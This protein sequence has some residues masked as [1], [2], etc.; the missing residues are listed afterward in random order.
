[1]LGGD[2]LLAFVFTPTNTALWSSRHPSQTT[3]IPGLSP[4]APG[5]AAGASLQLIGTGYGGLFTGSDTNTGAELWVTDGTA[6]GTRLLKDIRPGPLSSAPRSFF[7]AG[8]LTYFQAD[9]GLH[10]REIWCTD[11]T[12]TGTRLLKDIY[13]GLASSSSSFASSR[14]AEVNGLVF[15][16]AYEPE[17]GTEL[18]MTDGTEAGTTLVTD[19]N[20]Q[21]STLA[22]P[23]PAAVLAGSHDRLYF[24]ADNGFTGSEL[25]AATV[26]ARPDLTMT[27]VNRGLLIR[28][29]GE[30]SR[31]QIIERSSDLKVWTPVA[32]NAGSVQITDG[33]LGSNTFFRAYLSL[34]PSP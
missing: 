12:E 16:W 20:P 21:Q 1:V 31:N 18:W 27:P 14:M 11:G 17:H 10:G 15:F 4:P 13:P 32:T 22:S 2:Q 33:L 9:D 23:F 26:P 34:E 24:T 30:S 28:A 5:G 3:I 8:R 7:N 19:L 25:W 29:T 6:V